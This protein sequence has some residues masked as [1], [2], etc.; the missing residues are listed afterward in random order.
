M[1]WS[2][3]WRQRLGFTLG[4]ASPLTKPN[5]PWLHTFPVAVFT[6]MFGSLSIRPRCASSK[7][8]VSASGS[9]APN[10]AFAAAV[11]RLGGRKP[12]A[13]GAPSPADVGG[14]AG[15]ASPQAAHTLATR[16]RTRRRTRM[17]SSPGSRHSVPLSGPRHTLAGAS[18]GERRGGGSKSGGDHSNRTDQNAHARAR[19]WREASCR[20]SVRLRLTA[21]PASRGLLAPRRAEAPLEALELE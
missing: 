3:A 18:Y 9:P 8:M 1:P 10:C 4:G 21:R 11:V 14:A 16:A 17:A 20:D 13:S 5:R 12:F 7:S 19:R 15:G 6:S 2:F